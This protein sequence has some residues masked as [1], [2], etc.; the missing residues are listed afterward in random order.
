MVFIYFIS[1]VFIINTDYE[2]VAK[3]LQFVS[4]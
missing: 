1:R 2:A 3:N 4:K